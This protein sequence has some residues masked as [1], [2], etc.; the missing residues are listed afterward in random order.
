MKDKLRFLLM[1]TLLLS[2]S[3]TVNEYEYSEAYDDGKTSEVIE[4][5]GKET[6]PSDETTAGMYLLA[7]G[8]FIGAMFGSE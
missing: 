5:S 7:L 8:A 6:S 1:L 4:Y 2:T 3:C